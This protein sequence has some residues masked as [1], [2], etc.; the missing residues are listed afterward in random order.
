MFAQ[1]IPHKYNPLLRRGLSADHTPIPTTK[2][3]ASSF[4]ISS[5][6]YI[7]SSNS[8]NVNTYALKSL[9]HCALSM[10]VDG[11]WKVDQL[12]KKLLIIC[13][14]YPMQFNGKPIEDTWIS[15]SAYHNYAVSSSIISV[16]WV[17]NTIHISKCSTNV[18]LL[19][20]SGNFFLYSL[21]MTL[22]YPWQFE[23]R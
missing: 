15:L 5:S 20:F 21:I 9:I 23:G 1:F 13:N 22:L 4:T 19:T 6:A 2:L 8:N 12:R 17:R 11:T 10:Y 7:P 16:L 3:P 14:K 18:F